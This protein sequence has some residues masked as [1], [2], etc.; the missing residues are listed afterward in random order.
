MSDNSLFNVFKKTTMRYH[1][2]HRKFSVKGFGAFW[3]LNLMLMILS[4]Q[5]FAEDR[6][7][8]NVHEKTEISSEDIENI[9]LDFLFKKMPWDKD[10]VE[11]NNIRIKNKV[12]LPRGKITYQVMLPKKTELLGSTS[13]YVNFLING[14]FKRRIWVSAYIRVFTEVVVTKR[15]LGRYK[16]IKEGDIHLVNKDLAKLSSTVI[17]SGEE[18]LGKRAKRAIDSNVVL[19]ADHVELP[20]LVKRGDLVVIIVESD[21]MKL[22]ALGRAKEK[23][24]KGQLVRIENVDS[25]K[26]LYARVVDSNSVRVDF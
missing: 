12:V 20:P 14:K 23:G 11:I 1:M 5:T 18:V 6:M 7:T 16:L 17:T 19:R 10:K 4:A 15:P 13:L 24:R 26:G 21:G 8:I 3:A 25:N 9:V 22:T 2:D